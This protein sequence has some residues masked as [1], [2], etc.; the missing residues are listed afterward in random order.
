MLSCLPPQM[1]QAVMLFKSGK[2]TKKEY[3]FTKETLTICDATSSAT[4]WCVLAVANM[5]IGEWSDKT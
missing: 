2:D 4:E 5:S 1:Q 3:D